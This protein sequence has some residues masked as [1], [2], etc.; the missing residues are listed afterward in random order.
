MKLKK[1]TNNPTQNGWM[2]GEPKF[3]KYLGKRVRGVDKDLVS[4]Q[5]SERSV[6]PPRDES[7]D[8]DMEEDRLAEYV[9]LRFMS[10]LKDLIR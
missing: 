9:V 4:S 2:E 6:S 5:L 7:D 10:D 1:N 8:Q 3:K